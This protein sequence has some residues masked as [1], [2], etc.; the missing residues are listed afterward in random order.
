M[1]LRRKRRRRA[2]ATVR[3]SRTHVCVCIR[4]VHEHVCVHLHMCVP[5]H[6]H[7][8]CA[9]DGASA[10]KRKAETTSPGKADG[11]KKTKVPFIVPPT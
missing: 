4:G 3:L 7:T 2:K 8:L 6:A 9:A 11:G 5:M 1:A 10:K